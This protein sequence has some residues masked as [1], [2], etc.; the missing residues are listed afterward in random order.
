[1][2]D[3]LTYQLS[4]IVDFVSYQRNLIEV[5]ASEAKDLE[6]LDDAEGPIDLL[7]RFTDDEQQTPALGFHHM[8][9]DLY[10]MVYLD[11]RID[12]LWTDTMD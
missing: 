2:F 4:A 11:P 12:G 8:N 6:L 7:Y 10:T 5:P 9:G 1:M 3:D